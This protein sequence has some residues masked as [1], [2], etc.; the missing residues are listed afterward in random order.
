M[1]SCKYPNYIC[2]NDDRQELVFEKFTIWSFL[3]FESVEWK[4]Q[5]LQIEHIQKLKSELKS[6]P[7]IF[8]EKLTARVQQCG[9]SPESNYTTGRTSTKCI[10]QIVTKQKK[11]LTELIYSCTIYGL[12]VNYPQQTVSYLCCFSQSDLT[13]LTWTTS[14]LFP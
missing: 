13:E 12:I 4:P 6:F 1:D 11:I 14:R 2:T 5:V 10:I 8:I 9:N 7:I 3:W